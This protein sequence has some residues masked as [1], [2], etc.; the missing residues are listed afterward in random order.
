MMVEFLNNVSGV[1]M[2]LIVLI[3]LMVYKS[4]GDIN[5]I[6]KT[7]PTSPPKGEMLRED[8]MKSYR[9][10]SVIQPKNDPF[11]SPPQECSLTGSKPENNKLENEIRKIVREEIRKNSN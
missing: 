1:I 4:K 10:P 5:K 6:P 9:I 2:G 8:I 11:G 3:I 7:T